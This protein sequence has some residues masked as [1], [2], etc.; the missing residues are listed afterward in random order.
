MMACWKMGQRALWLVGGLRL[1]ASS[2]HTPDLIGKAPG[3]ERGVRIC[4]YDLSDMS[5]F[6]DS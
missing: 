4:R 3:T 5:L 6:A 1:E 2:V